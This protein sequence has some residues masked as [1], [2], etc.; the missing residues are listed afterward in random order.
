MILAFCSHFVLT[1]ENKTQLIAYLR[2]RWP[3]PVAEPR[4]FLAER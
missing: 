2:E 3:E 1:A 4:A